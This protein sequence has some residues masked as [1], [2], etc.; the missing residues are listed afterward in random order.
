[1][2]LP[3]VAPEDFV[4]QFWSGVTG[5]TRVI[6]ISHITSPTALIFPIEEICRRARAAGILTI[7]DGAHT[8]G[9]LP[10]NLDRLSADIY[11][12]N[13]HKWLCAPKGSAFLYVRPE[14]Q[15]CIEP[16]VVS[17]GWQAEAPTHSRFIDEQ[18]YTGTRDI[19]AYLA[20]PTA[21]KF[22][23]Q[24]H[25]EQVRVE[26]HALAVETQARVQALSG[27]APLSQPA[28]FAQMVSVR[29]PPCDLAALKARLYTEYQVE[30]P[31][32]RWRTD[33]LMRIS[34]Q[35]YNTR[36]DIERLQAGLQALL[37]QTIL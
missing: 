16:L 11:T 25:W 12:S 19:A 14:A 21:I 4:E 23:E 20:T 35:G 7:V 15:P 29:L 27:L 31:L 9:Q 1:V 17:W 18:E 13:C 6:F 33:Y 2:Q 8:V 36:A 37:P 30:V 34:I 26:C 24:H 22:L 3:L 10:L 28:S 5:R 32:L